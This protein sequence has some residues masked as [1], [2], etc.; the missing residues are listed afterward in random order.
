MKSV[1]IAAG[2]ALIMSILLTP[3]AIRLFRRHGLG[4]EIRDDGPESHLS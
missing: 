3:V 2:I 1:L 4:Q